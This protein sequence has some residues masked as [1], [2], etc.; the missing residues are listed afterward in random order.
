MENEICCRYVSYTGA[1]V[2][3]LSRERQHRYDA[4][5]QADKWTRIGETR[6]MIDL[7]FLHAGDH[8]NTIKLRASKAGVYKIESAAGAAA[9]RDQEESMDNLREKT[10]SNAQTTRSE[11][12]RI[13]GYSRRSRCEGLG[14]EVNGF[15]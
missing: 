5:W 7:N 3:G 12:G 1:A 2:E 6:L 4:L 9:A 14:H 15:D 10:P 8:V 13:K 11:K